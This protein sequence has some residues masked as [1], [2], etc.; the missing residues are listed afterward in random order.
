LGNLETSAQQ[1]AEGERGKE[2]IMGGEN[3][4]VW[5]RKGK[6]DGKTPIFAKVHTVSAVSKV[7][8]KKSKSKKGRMQK[9]SRKPEKERSGRSRKREYR[10][11]FS[12]GS[13]QM[14]SS[15]AVR[16]IGNGPKEG[17]KEMAEE[18]VAKNKSKNGGRRKAYKKKS[19]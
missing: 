7:C 4:E 10:G 2:N 15:R 17:K 5:A 14:V 8:K 16:E 6:E 9:G 19:P 12:E 18:D 11:F 3:R 13:T 1:E